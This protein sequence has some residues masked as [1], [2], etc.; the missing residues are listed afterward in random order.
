M[1]GWSTGG[2]RCEAPRAAKAWAT[3]S[4]RNLARRLRRA[5]CAKRGFDGLGSR[6][7]HLRRAL[8]TH[9]GLESANKVHDHNLGTAIARAVGLG[10]LSDEQAKEARMVKRAGDIARHCAFAGVATT[11]AAVHQA[12]AG[13]GPPPSAIGQ[14]QEAEQNIDLN[15]VAEAE[16]AGFDTCSASSSFTSV[17]DLEDVS[18]PSAAKVFDLDADDLDTYEVQFFAGGAFYTQED[19][20]AHLG[21]HP[22]ARAVADLVGQ[23]LQI[24]RQLVDD[25]FTDNDRELCGRVGTQTSIQTQMLY[26]SWI[27]ST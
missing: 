21:E 20:P 25:A 14:G 16:E 3:A 27:S 11:A 23:D 15:V 9:A 10:I 1:C 8:R 24:W 22:A 5:A 17:I 4:A 18:V 12:D 2:P 6:L 19:H 13:A 26:A 7:K